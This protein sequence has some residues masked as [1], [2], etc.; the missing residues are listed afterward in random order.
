MNVLFLMQTYIHIDQADA[1]YNSLA[2]QFVK[3]GHT[4]TVVASNEGKG[5]TVLQKE[6]SAIVL[7]VKTLP[8]LRVH[9]YLKGIANLLLGM[10]YRFAIKKHLPKIHF[11]L[12]VTPTP[13]I[14][15]TYLAARLKKK[16]GAK[17]YLILR[18]IFP[19]NAVDIGLMSK[20]N[21]FY[22]IFRRMERNLYQIADVIGCMTQGN[23]DYLI[24]HNPSIDKNKLAIL[25]NWSKATVFEN[26]KDQTIIDKYDLKNKFIVIFGGNLGLP[27]KIENIVD[28]AKVHSDK[29]NLMF[30]IIGRGTQKT[31]FQ[32]MVKNEGLS[33]FLF[34]DFLP[35]GEY[36]KFVALADVGLISL[37]ENF[38]I[39]NIPS[40]T[41]S[42][43]NF[44]KPVFAIIDKS[45]DY[46][47]MLD[48]D[49]S[50]FWSHV[51]NIKIYISKFNL[52][53]YSADLREEMGENGYYA[54]IK[55][56]SPELTY[57]R[58]K[59]HLGF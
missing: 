34:I 1:M 15:L 11:D 22:L 19:Q 3:D 12:I 2:E 55:N 18:D 31:L 41:L 26:E 58:I 50:G 36:E 54:L 21:L 47:K 10:Q 17:I 45:T 23:I 13:P 46:P 8:L 14:T 4:V 44:K 37:N 28:F 57:T 33:N 40:R 6:G 48:N 51:G 24:K 32:N 39:P 30:V 25:P 27:Q 59:N 42:Y 53:Y 38:T 9:P 35:R 49:L 20:R 56:Y 52:L 7:R 29:P 43:Y 5:S 16:Y